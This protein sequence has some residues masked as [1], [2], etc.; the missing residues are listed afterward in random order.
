[1][2]E[3]GE[4]QDREREVEV[5]GVTDAR[6][7]HRWL[8]GRVTHIAGGHSITKKFALHAHKQNSISFFQLSLEKMGPRV[9]CN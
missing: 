3:R 1:M 9:I 7:D 4:H 6:G 5:D 8:D 2:E